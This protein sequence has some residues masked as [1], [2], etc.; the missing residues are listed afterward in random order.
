MPPLLRTVMSQVEHV[1]QI[2]LEAIAVRRRIGELLIVDDETD[3]TSCAGQ[4]DR[5][6][7]IALFHTQ[8]WCDR[9]YAQV[10]APGQLVRG[11][12]PERE[13]GQPVHSGPVEV[14]LPGRQARAEIRSDGIGL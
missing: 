5:R 13:A 12:L 11:G 7:D 8:A 3:F 4:R 10:V 14:D 6:S 2:S 1:V 9:L